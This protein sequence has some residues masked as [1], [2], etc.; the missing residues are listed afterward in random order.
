MAVGYYIVHDGVHVH[1]CLHLYRETLS[2]PL[3]KELLVDGE[4]YVEGRSYYI[5]H[6]RND[7]TDQPPHFPEKRRWGY[8]RASSS[9]EGAIRAL[10]EKLGPW[11]IELPAPRAD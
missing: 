10:E 8:A 6:Y 11:G 9:P 2:D 1:H 5:A 4:P 3:E 7:G